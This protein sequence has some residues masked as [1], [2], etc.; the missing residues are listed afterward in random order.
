MTPNQPNREAV[1]ELMAG[2]RSGR[3]DARFGA[4]RVDIELRGAG[5]GPY[6]CR[7]KSFEW[8]VDEPEERGGTDIG[9]NP[10]AH[11]VSGAAT[12]L[13][14]HWMLH[15]IEEG[16]PIEDLTLRARMRFDRSMPGG[17]ITE[18]FYDVKLRSSAG[19]EALRAL[20]ERA[21]A[22]CYAHNTLAAANV[23][24]TTTIEL[25]GERLEPLVV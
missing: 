8:T 25:D 4:E 15:A 21:Q 5:N 9:A 11:F 3:P 24:L 7:K 1:N 20:A 12:C 14:S 2:R 13:L 23:T 10:L 19:P 22:S 17:R 16:V 6:V 18:V